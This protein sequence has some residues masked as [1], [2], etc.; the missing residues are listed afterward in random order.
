MSIPALLTLPR[1]VDAKKL[2]LVVLAHGG[3]YVRGVDWEWNRERQFIASR[4]YAVLEPDFRG[5]EGHGWKLFSGGFKQWG[6]AMQDDLADGVAELVK[7]GIVDKD[8]VCIAGA[9]YGG[10]AVVMGLIRHPEVY[11]CGVSWVGVT[12]IDLMYSVGWSDTAD[13]DWAR[14]GMPKRVGDP[15]KDRA[16][17]DATSALRQAGRLKL[18][19][20]MAYGLEDVRVPYEH[21]RRLRDALK[22][23][24]PN[25]E[26]LEYGGEGHGWRL[27]P[28]N[29]DFWTRVEKFLARH[30]GS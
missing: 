30:I 27:P 1:G 3:P 12:D 26:Y 28:T 4:G 13:S 17:L 23:H 19:L 16:Q 22:P 29:I 21:G 25:V 15:E 18:P 7:R 10:Y 8:K 11:R 2:P 20:L 5:S 9:S 24:N 14:Y 6:L